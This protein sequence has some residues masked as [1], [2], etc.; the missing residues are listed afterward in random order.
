MG[1]ARNRGVFVLLFLIACGGDPPS[2]PALAPRPEIQT[3]LPDISEGM[4]ARLSDTGCFADSKTLEPGP[5]LIPYDV[6]SAL[7]TDGAFKSRFMVVPSTEQIEV[8]EDGQWVF[9]E[10]SVLIKVFGF[11]M[12]V[13][14]AVSPRA[15]ETRFMVRHDGKWEYA[16]YRWNDDGTDGVLIE[17]GATVEYTVYQNGEPV[18]LE[19]TFPD[20]ET[21]TTCHGTTIDDVLGP[22][23]NQLNRDRDYGGIV[24]NQLRAMDQIDLL[25]FGTTEEVNPA[26][27]PTIANPQLGVGTLDAQ[28]RAYLDANCA[29]CHRPG[30][31]APSDIGLDFRYE[32]TLEETGLC[33]PMKY[34]QWAGIPRVL[35]GDSEG[36]GLLQR[37]DRDDPLRMPSTGT[38]AVDPLGTALLRGWIDS[39][40]TC[41]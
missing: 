10:G 30:G 19:Y 26:Q 31:W 7:W 6:S 33:E 11:D 36:S 21:C 22:K 32:V 9:P 5:D 2:G 14:E 16:T 29:H 1:L 40:A 24:E 39:L 4:P 27:L 23:T 18:V 15:V 3:C 8:R 34:F 12:L 38:S 25:D 35:P 37:F 41:P 28:A 17:G 20:N 13:D